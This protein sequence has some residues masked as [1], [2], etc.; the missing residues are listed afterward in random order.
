MRP[1]G[2]GS[3]DLRHKDMMLSKIEAWPEFR[4]HENQ[5]GLWKR[6]RCGSV[7]SPAC[8]SRAGLHGNLKAVLIVYL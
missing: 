6:R 4:V 5:I 2:G 7:F 3:G 1:V 8:L